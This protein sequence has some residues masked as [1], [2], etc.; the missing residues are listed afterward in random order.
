MKLVVATH[1]YMA[2]GI[3]SALSIV[4][5]N[6]DDIIDINA[7]TKDCPDPEA[8]IQKLLDCYGDDELLILTDVYFGGVNQIFLRARRTRKFKLVTGVS[9]PLAVELSIQMR[10]GISDERLE[11]IVSVC[12]NETKVI[13]VPCEQAGTASVIQNIQDEEEEL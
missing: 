10:G 8:E 7:F 2:K 9:L 11:E 12:R 4:V 6:V 3:K 5:D 1:G 13:P